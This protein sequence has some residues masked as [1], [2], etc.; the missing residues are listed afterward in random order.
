MW[1]AFLW[2]KELNDLMRRGPR[3][4]PDRGR[5]TR[6]PDGRRLGVQGTCISVKNVQI[7]SGRSGLPREPESEQG[8]LKKK[9]AIS[10]ETRKRQH[11]AEKS[12]T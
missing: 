9:G 1:E 5:V 2:G 6:T 3:A 8:S 10:G 4:E 11:H 12:A 7:N